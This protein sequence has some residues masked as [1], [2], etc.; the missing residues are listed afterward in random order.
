MSGQFGVYVRRYPT[1]ASSVVSPEGGHRPIWNPAGG[2]VFYQQ[3]GQ[4]YAVGVH[5]FLPPYAPQVNPDE[6]VWNHVKHHGVGRAFVRTKA[7]L[8]ACV[9]AGPRRIQKSPWLIRMFFL[10]PDTRYAAL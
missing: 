8:K 2:E 7:D 10:P 1:G 4:V 3:F 5:F 6:Q 9:Q